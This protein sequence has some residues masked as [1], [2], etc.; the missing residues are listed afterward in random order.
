MSELTAV[1]LA[2][3]KGT[4][5]KS[6][7][8]KVLHV[9]AGQPMLAHV[10][11]AAEIAG[12]A[13]KIVVIGF[14]AGKVAPIVEG[15]AELVEQKEQLGTGHAVMQA[16]PLL[17][18]GRGAVMILCGDTPLLDGGDLRRFYEHHMEVGNKATV[19][20]ALMDDPAGYGRV[21]RDAAG[22][23][24]KIVEQK[25]ASLEE[26]A[27][28]EI[29][30]GIY[31]VDSQLLFEVLGKVDCNNAQG[32]YYLTDV[33][34]K[35]VAADYKVGA[36]VAGDSDSVMGVN[37]RRDLAEAEK[38][39]RQ[40]TN[41][42][43]MDSGVTIMDPGST[44]IDRTVSI[45]RDTII[46]PYTWLEGNTVIGAECVV[47]PNVRF[48]NVQTGNGCIV[49]FTYAH[50]AAIG[51]GV[52]VGPFAHLRPGTR[53]ADE[54]KVGNFV[55]VKNSWVGH[56]SKLP[57]LSYIGDADIGNGVNMGCGTITVNYDGKK[58]FRTTIGDNAFVGCNSNLVAP[59]TVSEGAYIGAGSTITHDVPPG[60]LGIGRAKQKNIDNWSK[61]K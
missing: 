23:V 15:R 30:T 54:V 2:A 35:L 58:K 38:L 28:N 57:H 60:A 32:E 14:G 18:D 3:G 16:Q 12:C 61:Y 42:N 52:T 47:G 27:I 21:V 26:L 33:I 17:A 1:I 25:D 31:C 46:Y 20:T 56:G 10:L 4:R 34:D 45:G 44:Y 11:D 51:N 7:L 39:L 13:R 43:L 40:R 59:V 5:M 36:V 49:H 6:D 22:N 50:D 24:V 48:S 8:P 53:L 19:L 29:N 37:S 9:V 41:E 55:E